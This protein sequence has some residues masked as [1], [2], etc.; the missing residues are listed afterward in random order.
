ML[1][2]NLNDLQNEM[3]MDN[4]KNDF[5]LFDQGLLCLKNYSLVYVV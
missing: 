2:F 4:M 3:I 5:Y 1:I